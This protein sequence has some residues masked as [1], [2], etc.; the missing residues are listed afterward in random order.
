MNLA[1]KYPLYIVAILFVLLATN[2]AYAKSSVDAESNVYKPSVKNWKNTVDKA[3]F[4]SDSWMWNLDNK[5]RYHKNQYRS[6][7]L[8]VPSTSIPDDITLVVW[9]HGLGG[10]TQSGFENRILPQMEFLVSGKHSFALAIPEMPW[11]INTSTPRGR[12]GQ[13]WKRPGELEKYVNSARQR[14]EIWSLLRHQKPLGSVRVIFIGHSA[15]GSALMAAAKEGSLCRVKPEAVIWSD[16]S[17]GYWLDNTMNSCIKALD[18]NLHILVR[19]WDKPHI[20]AERVMK[21]VKRLNPHK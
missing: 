4:T 8:S 17:Y 16:A 5:D 6:S 3:T 7:V 21:A 2:S 14:L 19:K 15:G 20:G 11:S 10:F 12:Q 13:V 9:F 1:A 18:T